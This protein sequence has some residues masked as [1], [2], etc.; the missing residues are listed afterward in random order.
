MFKFTNYIDP[1]SFFIAFGIGLLI[2]YA[3]NPPKKIVIKWPTP[4]NAGKVLYKDSSENCYKYEA[5]E[6]DCPNDKSTIKKTPIQH[7]D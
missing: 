6:I 1:L 2:T 5:S 4:E 7:I 3:T